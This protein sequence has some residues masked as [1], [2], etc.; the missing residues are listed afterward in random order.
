MFLNKGQ[1]SSLI[2]FLLTF[3]NLLPQTLELRILN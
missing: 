2:Y 3:Q 1:I